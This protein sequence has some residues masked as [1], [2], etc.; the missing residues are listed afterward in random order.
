MSQIS[1]LNVPGPYARLGANHG[2]VIDGDVAQLHADVE[3]LADTSPA[4]HWALQLWA[5]D[6]PYTDG[7]V[8]GVKVAEAE[9]TGLLDASDN[10]R[11]LDTAAQARVPGGQRDYAMVL[12]LASGDRGRYNQ[13]HDFAN[14][15]S[16]Q[17]FVTPHLDG[18]VSYVID[19]DQVVLAADAVCSPRD[20]DNI[21]GTLSLELWAL[22]EPYA[23]GIFEGHALGRVDLGRLPGQGSLHAVAARVPFAPPPAGSWHIVLMLREWAGLPGYVTRDYARFAVPY[24]VAAATADERISITDDRISINRGTVEELSALKGLSRKV[25]AEIVKGRPYES[26]DALLDVKGIGPKLLDKL[27]PFVS[28]G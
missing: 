27:R 25:A 16:R 18:A 23:G 5:C 3:F 6:A 2:Y 21:S 15:P 4:D 7:P 8:T 1:T 22:S 20:A 28:L 13:V 26:I 17:R 19:G 14:Y 10:A 12:V 9:L 11:R 24:V